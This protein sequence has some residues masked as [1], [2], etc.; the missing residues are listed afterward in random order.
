VKCLE[1]AVLDVGGVVIRYGRIYGP[2]TYYV[3]ALP[4]PPHVY[5]VEAA[6]LSVGALQAP[7]GVMVVAE[8][9]PDFE[10]TGDQRG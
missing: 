10:M 3:G 4:P 2:G 5:V 9:W 7:S 8:D 1:A 6:R